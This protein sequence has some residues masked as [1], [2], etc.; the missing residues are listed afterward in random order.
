MYY[1]KDI[2][3]FYID[4]STVML[5]KFVYRQKPVKPGRRR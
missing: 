3:I 1:E 4:I 2:S 5:P